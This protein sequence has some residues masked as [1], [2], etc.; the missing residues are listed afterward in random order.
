MLDLLEANQ[1]A[2]S[3]LSRHYG[4]TRLELFGSAATGAFKPETSDIDLLVVFKPKPD[5][6]LADQYFGF[7]HDLEALLGRSVDLV[8]LEAVD[9]PYFLKAIASERQLVYAG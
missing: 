7:K 9:N 3:E 5:L 1:E 6:G 2:L 4:V 8:E